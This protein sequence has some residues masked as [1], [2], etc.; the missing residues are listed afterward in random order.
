MTHQGLGL[1]LCSVPL[2]AISFISPKKLGFW[3]GFFNQSFPQMFYCEIEKN[4]VK[5]VCNTNK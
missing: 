3:T 4:W 2:I 5:K 1:C